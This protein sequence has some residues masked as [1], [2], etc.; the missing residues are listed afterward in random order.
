MYNCLIG[1]VVPHSRAASSVGCRKIWSSCEELLISR[2]SEIS[3]HKTLRL[4]T[5]S[6]KGTIHDFFDKLKAIDTKHG[7]FDLVLCVGDFFA[8]AKDDEIRQ[9]LDGELERPHYR[10]PVSSHSRS[11]CQ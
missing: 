8:A 6:V 10:L 1:V 9:L 7:K 3:S 2:K 4:T 11:S 5:G